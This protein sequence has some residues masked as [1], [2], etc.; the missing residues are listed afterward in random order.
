LGRRG[1]SEDL[2]PF[3]GLFCWV[4]FFGPYKKKKKGGGRGEGGKERGEEGF[5]LILKRGLAPLETGP[6]DIKRG[7][8]YNP[9]KEGNCEL[10]R[11]KKGLEN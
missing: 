4:F 3:L 10:K 9:P 1:G 7:K 2:G 6:L 5:K 11:E 8:G